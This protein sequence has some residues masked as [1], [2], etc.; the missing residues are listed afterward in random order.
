MDGNVRCKSITLMVMS[1][2]LLPSPPCYAGSVASSQARME[3]GF[4]ISKNQNAE[5]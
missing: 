2:L 4:S 5:E 3:K 1:G